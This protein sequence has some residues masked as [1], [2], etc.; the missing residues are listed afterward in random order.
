MAR[1]KKSNRR[2]YG[3][4]HIPLS[5]NPLRSMRRTVM[6]SGQEWIMQ[7][8]SSSEKVYLC[9]WCNQQISIG[10][11][12]VVAWPAETIMGSEAGLAERRHWHA[13]CWE[14]FS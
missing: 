5:E 9:P 11:P 2:Q 8:L 14:K 4:A 6:V 13:G 3:K 7:R 1:S 10:S 12:Q